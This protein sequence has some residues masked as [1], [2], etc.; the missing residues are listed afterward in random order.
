MGKNWKTTLVG[1]VM[2]ALIVGLQL[3]Q[4]GTTDLKTIAVAVA[5]AL[6]GALAKDF[7]VTGTGK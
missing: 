1:A 2:G 4:T 5:V 3:I 7:N 6:L